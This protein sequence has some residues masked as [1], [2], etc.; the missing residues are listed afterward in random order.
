[1]SQRLS[2]KG[3][4]YRPENGWATGKSSTTTLEM[5]NLLTRFFTLNTH[6]RN[7]H[8][9]SNNH[10]SNLMCWRCKFNWGQ[11]KHKSLLCKPNTVEAGYFLGTITFIEDAHC[12]L[13]VITYAREVLSCRGSS[14]ME[15][16]QGLLQSNVQ[17]YN[18]G[19]CSV[20]WSFTLFDSKKSEQV[21]G[22]CVYFVFR[23]NRKSTL[24]MIRLI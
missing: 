15:Q 5:L 23:H 10:T 18:L 19:K 8:L 3:E 20:S 21:D 9:C 17:R 13:H 12:S 6:A 14:L 16:L 7:R 11:V 22:W 24:K 1:M 4:S 2:N